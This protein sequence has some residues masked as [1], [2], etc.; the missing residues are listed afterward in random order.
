MADIT[1]T[2]GASIRRPDFP[3]SA[4]E[5]NPLPGCCAWIPLDDMPALLDRLSSVA[6]KWDGERAVLV[7]EFVKALPGF[8]GARLKFMAAAPASNVH[9]VMGCEIPETYFDLVSACR[10]GA[11]DDLPQHSGCSVVGVNNPTVAHA[12]RA[13]MARPATSSMW[14]IA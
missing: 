4:N 6:A 5:G 7:A 2:L 11:E 9:L 12:G 3:F 10:A 14:S 8:V 13:V 1:L